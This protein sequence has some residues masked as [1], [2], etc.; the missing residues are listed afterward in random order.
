M[1]YKQLVLGVTLRMS[2]SRTRLNFVQTLLMSTNALRGGK[3]C[4]KFN[5]NPFSG[6]EETVMND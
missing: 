6:F 5:F 2:G 3:L 1:L 4:M